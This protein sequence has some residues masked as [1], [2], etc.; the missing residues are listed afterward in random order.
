ML[1][2]WKERSSEI[3]ELGNTKI[4][5]GKQLFISYFH[6]L[7]CILVIHIPQSNLTSFQ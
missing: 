1:L 4:Q 2:L 3:I 7:S 5:T 6:F